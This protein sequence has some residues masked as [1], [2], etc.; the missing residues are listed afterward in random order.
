M[1]KWNL[2][3]LY[4]SFDSKEFQNDLVVLQEKIDTL[5]QFAEEN[6][7]ST[8]NAAQKMS[9]FIELSES[10]RGLVGRAYAFCSLTISTDAMNEDA[11]TKIFE[12]K[13]RPTSNPLILHFP[14]YINFDA[15]YDHQMAVVGRFETDVRSDD[16]H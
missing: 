8:D 11:I 7:E 16:A 6:F 3:A 5:N 1:K 10:L 15:I 9:S 14:K 4:K 2:D 12:A 13:G